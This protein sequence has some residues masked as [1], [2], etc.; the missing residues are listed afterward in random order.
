MREGV[1]ALPSSGSTATRASA[2]SFPSTPTRYTIPTRLPAEFQVFAPRASAGNDQ[3]RARSASLRGRRALH[4]PRDPAGSSAVSPSGSPGSDR[5]RRTAD[6]GE[7]FGEHGAVGHG[8]YLIDPVLR[9]PLIPPS[10]CAARRPQGGGSGLTRRR[11]AH[12]PRARRDCGSGRRAGTEPPSADLRPEGAAL[13]RPRDPT[14]SGTTRRRRRSSCIGETTSGSSLPEHPPS[15]F[16]LATDPG[17]NRAPTMPRSSPR[18]SAFS[19]TTRTSNGAALHQLTADRARRGPRSS[20]A[21]TREKLRRLGCC[22]VIEAEERVEGRAEA[23]EMSVTEP[24]P[25]RGSRPRSNSVDRTGDPV[26]GGHHRRTQRQR[27]GT[28]QSFCRSPPCAVCG[29]EADLDDGRPVAVRGD[30]VE[31]GLSARWP[32]RERG[33]ALLEQHEHPLRLRGA[34]LRRAP[35]RSFAAR[36]AAEAAPD[37]IVAAA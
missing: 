24:A 25:V 28:R 3:G 14:A 29:I 26:V 37:E 1:S 21:P 31:P 35:D 8:F 7:A 30:P 33:R 27:S 5:R 20:I 10:R 32:L 12:D 22:G 19:R 17:E 13:S 4:G 34:P 11:H 6:H 15:V 9:V 36:S 16:D 23:P 2:S 18:A